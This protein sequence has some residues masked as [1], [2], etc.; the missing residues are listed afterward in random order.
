[1][2]FTGKFILGSVCIT[3][4]LTADKVAKIRIIWLYVGD[5]IVK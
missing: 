2:F 4:F 3:L 1:M 5:V